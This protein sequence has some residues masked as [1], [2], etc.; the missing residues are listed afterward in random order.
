MP[1]ARSTHHLKPAANVWT[2]T[3]AGPER[4]DGEGPYIW[5]VNA[6][7]AD[8]A[9][10]IAENIHRTTQDVTDI[11]VIS[12]QS[13]APSADYVWSYNDMRGIPAKTIVLAPTQIRQIAR[14][15]LLY[16]RHDD[17]PTAEIFLL[18]ADLMADQGYP[19]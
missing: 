2:V 5:V 18:I 6:P 4:H 16:K 10:A 17:L 13:G 14:V 19:L 11:E 8:T 15:R 1:A 9:E 7:D 3:V 12:T